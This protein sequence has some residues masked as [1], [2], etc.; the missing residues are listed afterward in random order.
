MKKIIF[1][2]AVLSAVLSACREWEPVFSLNYKA[3][4]A[5]EQQIPEANAK[6]VDIKKLYVRNGF[7]VKIEKDLVIKGQVISSD[8]QGNVYRSLF[9]QDET[10]GIE[11]KIGRTGLYNDYKLGQWIYVKCEGLTIGQ[12]EGVLQLGFSPNDSEQEKLDKNQPVKYE[13]SYLDVELLINKH[14]IRGKYDK[15]VTP[16]T[17]TENELKAALNEG[18]NNNL[19]STYCRLEGLTYGAKPNIRFGE[20]EKRIF[21]MLYI[22]PNRDRDLRDN[23]IFL[24]RSTYGVNTWAM[25]K[26]NFKNHL[27]KGDFDY[28]EGKSRNRLTEATK[29]TLRKYAS[30]V[31]VSQYFSL[32]GT[33]VQIRTSGYC[34][35]ADTPIDKDVL[36]GKKVI[37][38]EGILSVYSTSFQ[39]T[40]LDAES[41][42]TRNK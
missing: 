42:K 1:T 29:D 12:Y 4:E 33:P 36:E 39:F 30:A 25:S 16:K 10:G 28:P 31:T 13:T 40:L 27:D 18:M 22:N 11:I 38:V 5:V 6:I 26:E 24:S 2:V 15:P 20:E 37:D 41:V 9:I 34:K 35:F 19:Y 3:P 21:C 14:I 17:I 8:K 23:R 7:P 32:N